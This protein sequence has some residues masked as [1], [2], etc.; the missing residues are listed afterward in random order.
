VIREVF[1]ARG[2]DIETMF[3]FTHALV[4]E[5]MRRG[6]TYGTVADPPSE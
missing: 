4:E 2:V 1:A 3:P 6:F 5:S